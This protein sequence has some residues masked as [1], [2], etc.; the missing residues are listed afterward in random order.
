MCWKK[1]G[2]NAPQCQEFVPEY[3]LA[4]EMEDKDRKEVKALMKQ[5]PRMIFKEFTTEIDRGYFRG[6][7]GLP[8]NDNYSKGRV[9]RLWFNELNEN[10]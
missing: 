5:Y 2:V 6:R 3:D 4:Q 8:K 1:H 10:S 7:R 9:W